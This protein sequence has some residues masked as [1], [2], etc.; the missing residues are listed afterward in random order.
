MVRSQDD[1]DV[2][3]AGCS[4]NGRLA[5]AHAY[6]QGGATKD[7]AQIYSDCGGSSGAPWNDP[8]V[9]VKYKV[10]GARIPDCSYSQNPWYPDGG[11]ALANVTI[12]QEP[13]YWGPFSVGMFRIRGLDYFSLLLLFCVQR[14]EASARSSLRASLAGEAI[15]STI[16]T[17]RRACATRARSVALRRTPSAT[18]ANGRAIRRTSTWRLPLATQ[19]SLS[20][21]T[22]NV[23]RVS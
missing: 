6:N 21:W 13:C 15:S 11:A 20:D 23:F 22:T 4:C 14:L 12:D 1:N 3:L 19:R 16:W 7:C 2:L 17:A 10:A 9:D 18:R 5:Y 8:T